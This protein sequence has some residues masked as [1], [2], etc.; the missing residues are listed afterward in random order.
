MIVFGSKPLGIVS[1]PLGCQRNPM[2][3]N[4]VVLAQTK[5]LPVSFINVLGQ[6]A[7]NFLILGMLDSLLPCHLCGHRGDIVQGP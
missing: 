3:E 1:V 5:H 6:D 4:E 7:F 2:M